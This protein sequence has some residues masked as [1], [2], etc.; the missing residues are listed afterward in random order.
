MTYLEKALR[1]KEEILNFLKQQKNLIILSSCVKCKCP[2]IVIVKSGTH[3][4]EFVTYNCDGDMFCPECSNIVFYNDKIAI[5]IL[6]ND[7]VRINYAHKEKCAFF[8]N[9]SFLKNDF[10]ETIKSFN[11]NNYNE[12]LSIS[13]N[14]HKINTFCT[15]S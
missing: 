11:L 12:F 8:C 2:L 4:M 13:N 7:N 14:F 1:K 15:G 3:H 6:D 5:I 10:Y 9:V